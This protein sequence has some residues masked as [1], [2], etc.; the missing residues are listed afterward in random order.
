MIRTVW[1]A[2]FCL[3]SLAVIAGAKFISAPAGKSVSKIVEPLGDK[4]PDPPAVKT[5][6]LP[7]SDIDDDTLPDKVVV[8]TLKI[9][10][11]STKETA[12]ENVAP[13]AQQ[14][15]GA[16]FAE[17]RGRVHHASHRHRRFR[18]HR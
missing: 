2:L 14:H 11:Q 5:D 16:A 18:R 8:R 1:L 9:V 12:V 15:S 6:K 17:L 7:T 10:P 3:I 13:A 4:N